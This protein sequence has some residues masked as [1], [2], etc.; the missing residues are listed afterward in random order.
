MRIEKVITTIDSHTGG[1]PTRVIT[2]GLPHIPGDTM[3]EKMEYFRENLDFIRTAIIHEPR[4]HKYMFGAVLL[5]PTKKEA[6]FG[7][8]YLDNKGCNGMCGHGTIG[9]CVTLI[10]TG[11]IPA[12]EP[13]TEIVLDTPA[14]LV[15]TKLRIENGEVMSASLVNLPSFLYAENIKISLPQGKISVDVSFG[16]SFFTLI[17]GED[18]EL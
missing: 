10:K 17:K 3:L 9:I 1:E 15:S 7:A 5:P 13:E 16:G 14:G 11:W 6:D 12:S 18:L 4:G 8:F 2:G